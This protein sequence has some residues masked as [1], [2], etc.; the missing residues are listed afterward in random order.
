MGN[1]PNWV[2][3][4]CTRASFFDSPCFSEHF[5]R[6]DSTDQDDEDWLGSMVVGLYH[7]DLLIY[8]SCMDEVEII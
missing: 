5:R 6:P 4:L 8:A 1:I 2:R 3:V 7:H